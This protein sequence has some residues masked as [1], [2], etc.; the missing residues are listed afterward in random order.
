MRFTL[1][2]QGP[3][4]PSQTRSRPE[5][6]YRIRTVL[7]P[8][9][10]QF[11][12]HRSLDPDLIQSRTV[13]SRR[14]EF[15]IGSPL[16]NEVELDIV[17]FT[18]VGVARPGDVNNRL[19]TLTDGLACPTQPSADRAPSDAPTLLCLL[20]DDSLIQRVTVTPEVW[21]GRQD[22]PDSLAVISVKIVNGRAGHPTYGGSSLAS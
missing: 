13:G 16:R 12:Q 14:Y 6:N 21:Y 11:L 4:S 20:E 19:K 15:L 2:Y 22:D 10:R 7:D 9:L 1:T 5:A 17:L 18:P 3:L 8:Q